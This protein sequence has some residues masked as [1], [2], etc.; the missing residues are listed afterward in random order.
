MA[1]PGALSEAERNGPAPGAATTTA[2]APTHGRHHRTHR[3]EGH[4]PQRTERR[5]HHPP[6]K[7]QP[8]A[9][10]ASRRPP[11]G[12][13]QA[14]PAVGGGDAGESNCAGGGARQPGRRQPPH[15]CAPKGGAARATSCWP[16][17]PTDVPNGAISCAPFLGHPPHIDAVKK[18]SGAEAP[19]PVFHPSHGYQISPRSA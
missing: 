7:S 5:R 3:R 4:L 17:T 8:P 15:I 18:G 6:T 2:P 19:L 16:A 13:A 10:D 11:Q 14:R 12:G 1:A 9:R